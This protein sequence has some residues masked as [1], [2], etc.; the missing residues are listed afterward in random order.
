MEVWLKPVQFC[1]SV[2]SAGSGRTIFEFRLAGCRG[3]APIEQPE[4]VLHVS[5]FCA[6]CSCY[7]LEETA[8]GRVLPGEKVMAGHSCER[9]IAA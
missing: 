2:Q 5:L 7:G 1:S 3:N 6:S 8:S 4:K 9:S